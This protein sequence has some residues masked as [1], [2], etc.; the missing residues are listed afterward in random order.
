MVVIWLIVYVGIPYFDAEKPMEVE[1][2]L[3]NLLIALPAGV[4]YGYYR[5]KYLPARMKARKIVSFLSA[6][7][8]FISI[9]EHNYAL[10]KK[11]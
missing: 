10:K 4:G 5:Y 6:Y 3:L 8:R 2:N 1:N 7:I 9:H 11:I